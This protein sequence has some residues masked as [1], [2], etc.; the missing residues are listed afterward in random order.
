MSA[1]VEVVADTFQAVGDAVG[2]VAEVVT[3]AVQEVATVVEDTAKAVVATVEAVAEDPMKA[4]PMI[5]VAVAAPYVA[6]YLWAGATTATAAAVLNTGI[7]LAQGADPLDI[8]KNL[9]MSTVTQGIASELDLSTGYN[10]ADKAL[11]SAASAAIEGRDIENAIGSSLGGSLVSMGTGAI[12]REIRN[13]DYKDF[14]DEAINSSEMSDK[15]ATLL[16]QGRIFEDGVNS[17]IS[18]DEAA[19]IA[20]NFDPNAEEYVAYKNAPASKEE[21]LNAE[22]FKD[23]IEH[24][25]SQEEAAAI[26]KG[27][28]EGQ[29]PTVSNPVAGSSVTVEGYDSDVPETTSPITY[30][31]VS[32]EDLDK[33]L[34]DGE[35]DQE[36]YD[37][38]IKYASDLTES[39]QEYVDPFEESPIDATKPEETDLDF[40]FDA[41]EEESPIDATK[42]VA[43]GALNATT[44]EDGNTVY[45]YDD[46]STLTMDSDNKVM[47]VTEA[48][49]YYQE[50]DFD[51]ETGTGGTTFDNALERAEDGDYSEYEYL[52]VEDPKSKSGFS[53][54]FGKPS[55]ARQSS[56]RVARS[57]IAPKAPSTSGSNT[58]LTSPT[59]GLDSLGGGQYGVGLTS[60]ATKGNTDYSL[61]GEQEIEEPQGFASGGSSNSS[62]QG[63]YDLSTTAGSPFLGGGNS[64]IMALKPGTIKGKINYALPGY[65]FGQEW[66]AAKTGGSIQ[67]APAGHKPQFFSEG[68][69]GSMKNTYVKGKGDGTSDSIAA[70]LANGEF[71]IPADVVSNLGNGSNDAGA[72]VLDEF[73]RTIRA[74][75]RKA[76]P[77]GLPPDSKGA[78]G[79]LAT[80]KKKV[81]K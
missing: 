58:N 70:M 10:F 6:P 80:A 18:A 32:K 57:R 50:T 28:I 39:E 75:K 71:V 11:G 19:E 25:F 74:H 60:G 43:Y 49:D 78:L 9:A 41:P 69:L 36:T 53:L 65:P 42:P 72:K 66:K 45:T 79:Y 56:A 67:N 20:E 8:A 26:A 23:A 52:E 30:A 77:K 35:I 16:A 22:I 3:S 59:G 5:A 24:G 54:K 4:L 48:T 46:G 40:D 12:T 73:L 76:N 7:A 51:E 2:A 14:F 1:V 13:F 33:E 38:L 21:I 62:T 34:G 27:V 17:G 63:V 64:D 55:V 68:G 44:D 61:L 37:A 15:D 47:D 31:S 81:K 29:N